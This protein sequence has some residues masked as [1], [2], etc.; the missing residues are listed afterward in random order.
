MARIA[1]GLR[2]RGGRAGGR[3]FG[4]PGGRF[5]VLLPGRAGPFFPE[6]AGLFR[7]APLLAFRRGGWPDQFSDVPRRPA[8]AW[9]ARV[10]G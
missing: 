1:T 8:L 7:P 5:F 6:R 2:G 10:P 4:L 3:P 9:P